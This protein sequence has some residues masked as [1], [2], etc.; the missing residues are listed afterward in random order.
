MLSLYAASQSNVKL[1]TK[2]N[3]ISFENIIESLNLG[4]I[5]YP[6]L[7]TAE[8]NLS[9]CESDAKFYGK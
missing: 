3:R 8:T 1:I 4:S 7:I 6:K 2:V 9:V 5:I